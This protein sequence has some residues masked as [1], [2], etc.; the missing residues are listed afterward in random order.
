MT[1]LGYWWCGYTSQLQIVDE[2]IEE[3]RKAILEAHPE[4]SELRYFKLEEVKK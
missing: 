3:D 2:D 1:H 4:T